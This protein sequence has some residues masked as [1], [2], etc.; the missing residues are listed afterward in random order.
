MIIHRLAARALAAGAL[1]VAVT[2]CDS[3]WTTQELRLDARQVQ[4]SIVNQSPVDIVAVYE[5]DVIMGQE[6]VRRGEATSIE[7][8]IEA[9][10]PRFVPGERLWSIVLAKPVRGPGGE[11]LGWRT[12][13]TVVAGGYERRLERVVLQI[14]IEEQG[15]R[16]RAAQP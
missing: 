8:T 16:W 1:A 2:A 13:A 11:T 10:H 12:P 4:I 6:V 5:S 15:A 7:L 14:I 9:P 3:G